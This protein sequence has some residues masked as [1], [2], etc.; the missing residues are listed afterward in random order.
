MARISGFVLFL[1]V[2]I[3]PRAISAAE[4]TL[5]WDPPTDGLTTGYVIFV[6]PA[7]GMYSRQLSVGKVTSYTVDG[8]VPGATYYFVVKAHDAAGVLSGPSNEVA[9]LVKVA[10]VAPP[11]PGNC[12]TPDPFAALGG[13]TCRNGG[14]LPPGMVPA[15]PAAEPQP[16]PP[17]ATVPSDPAP[18]VVSGCV[19]PDPFVAMGGGACHN[20]GWLPPGMSPPAGAPSTPQPSTPPTAAPP[21]PPVAA[22][23]YDDNTCATDDPFRGIPG[24]VGLCRAGGWTPWP[25][26]TTLATA[27]LETDDGELVFV[28]DD[29][30]AYVVSASDE[31][32]P[33]TLYDGLRVLIRAVYEPSSADLPPGVVLIRI[34]EI[35]PE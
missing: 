27:Q 5:A 19:T 33:L 14:W 28:G 7:P 13:G 12:L 9:G 11:A 16:T 20:G 30:A 24:L 29:G 8:L 32:V 10:G 35:R 26:V 6:G 15:P 23:P 1:L 17:P 25:G 18:P 31:T 2:L 34:V 4:L 21:A 3:V 22:P